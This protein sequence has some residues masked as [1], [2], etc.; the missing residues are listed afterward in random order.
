M[1]S[2]ALCFEAKGMAWATLLPIASLALTTTGCT[3]L[4]P[5]PA[6]TAVSAVPL[7]RAGA[8]FQAAAVPGY[9]LSSSVGQSPKGAVITHLSMLVEP[10]KLIGVPGLIIGGRAVGNSDSGVYPEAMVGYRSVLDDGRRL[11]IA[12]VGFGTHAGT[13]RQN[14]SYSATRVGAEAALDWRATPDSNWLELHLLGGAS[15]TALNASGVYCL[16][17]N[18]Q[19]GIDCADPPANLTRAD[20]SGVYP[21]LNAGIALDLGRHLPVIFHGGRLALLGAAGTMPTVVGGQ[22]QSAR[23]YFALGLSLAFGLGASELP[24][25]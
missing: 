24:Q 5:M 10:D 19:Y 16:A 14:A 11:A 3:T 21:A 15:V 18:G 12:G 8:E 22:Q 13:T 2:L 9:F 6:T 25:R 7:G 1:N 20:A 23:S 17:A 4:G